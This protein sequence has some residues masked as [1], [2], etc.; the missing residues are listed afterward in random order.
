LAESDQPD[1][2][3]IFSPDPNPHPPRTRLKVSQAFSRGSAQF[4]GFFRSTML[5]CT[6]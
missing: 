1:K 6:C 4:L 5:H 3:A 2:A